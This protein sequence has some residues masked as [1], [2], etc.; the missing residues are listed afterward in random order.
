MSSPI[1]PSTSAI[2]ARAVAMAAAR[3]RINAPRETPMEAKAALQASFPLM[4]I[5]L[6]DTIITDLAKAAEERK[7]KEEQAAKEQPPPGE[8]VLDRE[9]PDCDLIQQALSE[10]SG[11][12]VQLRHNVR[13]ERAV[14]V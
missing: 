12:K 13:G 5:E 8:I 11:R 7:A 1:S 9:I 4:P 2:Q 14:I 6:I 10:A 3:L